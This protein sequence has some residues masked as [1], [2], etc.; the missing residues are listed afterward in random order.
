MSRV[1]ELMETGEVEEGEECAAW[2]S[3]FSS[4]LGRGSLF[5]I[6]L[7]GGVSSLQMWFGHGFE[8][9]L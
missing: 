7:R 9:S 4:A 6:G 1:R 3:S 8:G 5:Q 2:G